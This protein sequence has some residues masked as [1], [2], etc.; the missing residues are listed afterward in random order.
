MD[1]KVRVVDG[2][3]IAVRYAGANKIIENGIK[4]G[5][6]SALRIVQQ[7]A[8]QESPVDKGK[9]RQ[10]IKYRTLTKTRGEVYVNSQYGFW[11]HEGHSQQVGRFVPAIGKRLKKPYVKGNPFMDRA[12]RRATDP[13]FNAVQDSVRSE[14]KAKLMRE[15][16]II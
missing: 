1:I 3:K 9:L 16:G 6:E 7:Y 15:R 13:A 10:S 4:G 12:L 14:L 8:M 11:V 5:I 2:D